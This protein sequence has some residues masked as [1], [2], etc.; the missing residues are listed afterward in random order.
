MVCI[1]DNKIRLSQF[2]SLKSFWQ[3]LVL[4]GIKPWIISACIPRARFSPGIKWHNSTD[5]LRAAL[6]KPSWGSGPYHTI[7]CWNISSLES[8]P[9]WCTSPALVSHAL[10]VAVVISVQSVLLEWNCLE[11][12]LSPCFWELCQEASLL[13]FEIKTHISTEI[14]ALFPVAEFSVSY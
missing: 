11:I 14:L 13:C 6:A 2:I 1:W 12:I 4:P 5:V 10:G 8:S 3:S 9:A 7:W